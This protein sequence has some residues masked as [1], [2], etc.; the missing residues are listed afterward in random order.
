[1]KEALERILITEEQIQ[2]RLG[3]VAAELNRDY[4]GKFPMTVGILKGS[5]IFFADL[6]RRMNMPVEFDFMV[7]SSYGS[8]SVSSGELIIK[9]D[10]SHDVRG[11][12]VL[13]VEDIV[14]S[15][16]TL[17]KL[18]QLLRERGAASVKIVT[19]LD[20]KERRKYP[21]SPDYCCFDVEDEFVVGYGLDYAE[22][23]RQLPYIG[24]LKREYYES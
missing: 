14:D 10:L 3:E 23:F 15:G 13:I 7:V 19:L 17:T 22:K 21:I 2:T 11:R 8:G 20:K 4:E 9:K 18:T 5:V 6:V 1:M 24:I 16:F 12:D